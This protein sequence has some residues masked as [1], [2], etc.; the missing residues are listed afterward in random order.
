MTADPKQTKMQAT[1]DGREPDGLDMAV[2]AFLD[3]DDAAAE[4]R[5]GISF[6]DRFPPADGSTSSS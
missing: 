5:S 4:D 3:E 2:S 1:A 6:L